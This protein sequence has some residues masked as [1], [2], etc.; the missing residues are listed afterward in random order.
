MSGLE[1][2]YILVFH[3]SRTVPMRPETTHTFGN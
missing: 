1:L 3:M 2:K